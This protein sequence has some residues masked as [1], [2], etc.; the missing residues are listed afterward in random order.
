MDMKML[1]GRKSFRFYF[2]AILFAT[3]LAFEFEPRTGNAAY[4]IDNFGT[5]GETEQFT[6]K[7]SRSLLLQNVALADSKRVV[8]AAPGAVPGAAPDFRADKTQAA[9]VTETLRS[10]AFKAALFKYFKHLLPNQ[11]GIIWLA[12]VVTIVVAYDFRKHLS[13][14]NVDI[15]MLM[16]LS[17]FLMDLTEWQPGISDPIQRSLFAMVFFGIFSISAFFLVRAVIG[18]FLTRKTTTP[19]NL[20]APL[21]AVLTVVLFASNSFL[22]LGHQPNDSGYYTNLGAGKMLE[23]GKF[24]YGDPQLRDGAAAT[25]GPILYL[26]HIPFQLALSNIANGQREMSSFRQW[27]ISGSSPDHVGPPILATK[28]TV[29]FFHLLAVVGL[30]IIGQTLGEARIGWS[31]AALYLGSAYVQGLG[32]QDA[33][34]TGITY[35]SHI[36]P[37]ALTILAFAALNRPF[38]SGSILAVAAGALFYPVFFF[39]LWFGHY[40]WRGKEYVRFSTGFI[41]ICLVIGFTVLLLTQSSENESALQIIY[42]ST[43]GHQEAKGAYGSS[44]FSFWG[45]HPGFA[46]FWQTPFVEG[47]FLLR[48]SFLIFAAFIGGTFFM[49]HNR[50]TTQLAFLTAA[51]AIA[52]QLWKSHAGGTYVEW[53]Y[54]FLLIGL[55]APAASE[56]MEGATLRRSPKSGR[57]DLLDKQTANGVL[58]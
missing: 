50:T 56:M 37:A 26:S 36:A 14:R 41:L 13:W 8:D 23:T 40:F 3:L 42:K 34:I 47:W 6:D 5:R 35:V 39:P 31:L 24:P 10:S 15:L 52:I 53:Y 19:L 49:A 27:I 43:V 25:Y 11:G 28:L 9:S 18:A 30:V 7:N 54:P 48:P 20:P 33:F 32:G 29:L 2:A 4:V 17:L 16:V 1:I 46:S 38:W 22:A 57:L 51:I 21:A 45:L 44:T 55:F 58:S 12:I